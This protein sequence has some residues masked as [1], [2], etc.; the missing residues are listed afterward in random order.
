MQYPVMETIEARIVARS[1][2]GS[3]KT[4]NLVI[5]KLNLYIVG[6]QKT[7]LKRVEFSEL[8]M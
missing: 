6:E 1:I 7:W 3:R 2:G 8:K 5:S 4:T